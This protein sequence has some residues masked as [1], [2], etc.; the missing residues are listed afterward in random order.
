MGIAVYEEVDSTNAMLLSQ[1]AE[2]LQEGAWA[3]AERQTGGRGRHGRKWES[4]KGNLHASTLVRLRDGDPPPTTFSLVA[5]VALHRTFLE[6]TDISSRRLQIKWPNDL[7]AL[8][9]NEWGKIAGILIERIGSAVVIGFG[10][11]LVRAPEL[12]GRGVACAADFGQAPKPV[13][14]CLILE[15]H[16]ADELNRC[17]AGHGA[18]SRR[19]LARAHPVGTPLEVHSSPGERVAGTFDGIEPD[20]AL[21]LKRDGMTDI[22]RAGDVTLA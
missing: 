22:I 21:R 16:F 4:L 8:R 10:A 9:R 11:N 13:P 7:I 2:G 12:P 15:R 17:R 6:M 5:A 19:W 3:L 1:A 20:G 14:F 18:T